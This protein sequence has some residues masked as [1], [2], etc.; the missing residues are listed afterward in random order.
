MPD[1][2][3]WERYNDLVDLQRSLWA[4]RVKAELRG[5]SPDDWKKLTDAFESLVDECSR[6]RFW[7]Q[8]IVSADDEEVSQWRNGELASS[9]AN[10]RG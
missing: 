10:A 3:M 9:I 2:K 7:I 1:E 6:L 4:E 8:F 5:E